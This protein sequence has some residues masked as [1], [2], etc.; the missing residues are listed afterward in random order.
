MQQIRY[1]LAVAETRNF[2]RAAEQ[3]NVSQPAL[4]RAIKALEAE[5]GAPLVNRE[6]RNTHL[7]ELGRLMEPYLRTIYDQ[8]LSAKSA[9]GEF[10]ALGKASLKIG[11]MCTIGPALVSEFV[12]G[13]ARDFSDIDIEVRPL[14][15]AAL[16]ESLSSGALEVALLAFPGPVD[17]HLHTQPLFS[18]RFVVTTPN[19]HRFAERKLVSCRELHGET[20][21]NRAHCE[22]F[23]AVSDAFAARAIS[24]RQTFS[25]ECDE[26]VLAMIKAGLGIGF[27]PEFS[28]VNKSVAMTPIADPAFA[29][30]VRLATVRGRPH[31]PAVG[32]FVRAARLHRWP[33]RLE[34]ET[35]PASGDLGRRPLEK[36]REPRGGYQRKAH[37]PDG[38]GPA[39]RR[40]DPAYRSRAGEPA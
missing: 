35:A 23:D 7:T 2:T 26:W 37:G 33:A 10:M 24:M 8:S 19:D 17:E 3:C 1:F 4:T 11:V 13:F 6:H 28:V 39:R 25:S 12:A 20:Y 29:R 38:H 21:I 30:T 40:K 34:K 31:S 36:K 22:Y 27:F 9:A 32:A 16:R 5:L 15:L 18:E 14:P